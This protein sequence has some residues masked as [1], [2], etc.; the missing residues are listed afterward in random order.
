[1][2]DNLFISEKNISEILQ[3]FAV[4]PYEGESQEVS[5]LQQFASLSNSEMVY[6]CDELGNKIAVGVLVNNEFGLQD[7]K[8]DDFSIQNS[9]TVAV[10]DSAN[11]SWVAAIEECTTEVKENDEKD[12]E[13]DEIDQ[14][15]SKFTRLRRNVK[16]PK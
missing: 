7:N 16:L 12:R 13:T 1:M 6:A 11:A 15:P 2:F 8:F 9:S 5:T 4:L 10:D 3:P 14:L